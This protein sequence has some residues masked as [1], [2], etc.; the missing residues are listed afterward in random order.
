MRANA[1]KPTKAVTLL[2]AFDAS[3]NIT[4]KASGATMEAALQAALKKLGWGA[5]VQ[6]DEDEL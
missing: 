5:S 6:K 4:F 3:R 1:A 2:V